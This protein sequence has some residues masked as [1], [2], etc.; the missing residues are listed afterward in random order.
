MFA[1]SQARHLGEEGGVADTKME[2]G[3]DNADYRW[4]AP[5]VRVAQ[6]DAREK[7]A[8]RKIFS[9]CCSVNDKELDAGFGVGA[10]RLGIIRDLIAHAGPED[11]LAP[12]GKLGMKLAFEA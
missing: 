1:G 3:E 2:R 12:V 10:M 11:E 8:G 9:R 4:N 5:R 6:Q 7:P